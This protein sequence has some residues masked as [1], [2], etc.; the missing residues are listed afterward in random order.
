VVVVTSATSVSD[1]RHDYRQRIF[2]LLET[3]VLPL[4]VARPP[5]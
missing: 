3:H 2:D 1:E 4:A 5:A